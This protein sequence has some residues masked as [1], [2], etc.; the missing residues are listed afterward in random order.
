MVKQT[1]LQQVTDLTGDLALANRLWQEVETA[2]T[3]PVRYFHNL[4]HLEHLWQEL[5]PLHDEID[6]W[7]TLFFSLCYHDVVYDVSQHAVWN[8]NEERSAA[9]ATRHLTQIAYP[10]DKT[11]KCRQQILATQKHSLVADKDTNLFTDADLSILGQ[12]WPVYD[13]YKSNVRAEYLVYPIS[14]YNAGRRKVLE[15]FLRLEPLF[16]TDHFYRLY[17]QTAKE[18]ISKELQSLKD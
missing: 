12:P 13:E 17:E 9:F 6:D 2:Y 15:H 14:M 5:T 3:E 8:D 7:P 11:E 16:K 18:N 10:P 1:F 4:L